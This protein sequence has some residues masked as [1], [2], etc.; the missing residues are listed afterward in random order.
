MRHELGDA[1][2]RVGGE[3]HVAVGEDA[4]E[5]ADDQPAGAGALD[6]R[7]AG[8]TIGLHQ[9]QRVGERRVG[10]DHHRVHNHARFK[11]FHLANFFGLR[12]RIEV[13][14]DDADTACLR[15]GDREPRFRHRVHRCGEDRKVE[16]DRASQPRRDIGL[17]RKHLGTPGLQQHI[18][19]CERL[20]AG[21][22]VDDAGHA[23]PPEIRSRSQ[24]GPAA[25]ERIGFR[26]GAAHYH[27]VRALWKALRRRSGRNPASPPQEGRR[28]GQS[29]H[30]PY[31]WRPPATC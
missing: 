19:E 25:Q 4:D 28:F 23:K 31:G 29:V 6:D 24:A 2:R 18:I 13:A 16:I 8:D 1:L 27:D 30:G 7:D 17:A 15:H 21:D 12:V 10:T 20:A 9:R 5:L 22:D 14:V 26:I 11:L 3:A